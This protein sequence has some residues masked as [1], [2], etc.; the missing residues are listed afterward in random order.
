MTKIDVSF[1]FRSDTPGGLDPD[2]YSPTLREYHQVLWSKPL[3]DGRDFGL[4]RGTDSYLHHK[5]EVGEFWLASD[6]VIPDFMRE[7]RL[8]SITSRL[9]PDSVAAFD[10][11]GYTI[12]GMM[13]FPGE[14]REGK[15]TINGARGFHPRI[16]DRFDLTVECIRRHYRGEDSPLAEPLARYADFF[17]TF[18][19]FDGFVDFFLLEDLVESGVVRTFL[20]FEDFDRSPLPRTYDE[21]LTYRDNA[22]EFLRARNARIAAWASTQKPV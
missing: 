10:H 14:R 22:S 7:S 21:Y 13:L 1:N 18:G 9:D 6:T 15:M 11:L 4:A 3:P 2:T 17:E 16:K 8:L 19:D 20:P 5:S 12:G